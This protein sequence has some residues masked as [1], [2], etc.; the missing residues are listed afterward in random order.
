M[1]RIAKLLKNPRLTH[2]LRERRTFFFWMVIAPFIMAALMLLIG[3]WSWP[4]FVFITGC[5]AGIVIW[6]VQ[7]FVRAP[8]DGEMLVPYK[9]QADQKVIK[10]LMAHRR[11]YETT[12][13]SSLFVNGAL[14]RIERAPTDDERTDMY[15]NR[16]LS[17]F[18]LPLYCD[19][20]G[21]VICFDGTSETCGAVLRV[22]W[23]E[24]RPA[25]PV[26]QNIA[27]NAKAFLA[28]LKPGVLSERHISGEPSRKE[29]PAEYVNSTTCGA[30]T[31]GLV[32]GSANETK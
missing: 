4:I 29:F 28:L 17:K 9:G 27:K 6:L 25:D 24:G 3:R 16:A 22:S 1:N 7:L 8:L 31:E 14:V 12:E 11:N 5:I 18:V 10:E 23:P 32:R 13:G 30:E 15:C 21:G 2:R 20:E 26:T 19:S